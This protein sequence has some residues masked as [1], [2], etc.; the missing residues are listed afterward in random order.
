MG[1]P[2]FRTNLRWFC[3]KVGWAVACSGWGMGLAL[4]WHPHFR[5]GLPWF[6]LKTGM[7]R[8]HAMCRCG[9]E[10]RQLV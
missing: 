2:R 8:L 10:R 4:G 6:C 9:D 3:L 1:R 5:T 7:G